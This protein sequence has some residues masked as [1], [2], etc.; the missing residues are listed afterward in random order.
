MA[1]ARPR[2]TTPSTGFPFPGCHGGGPITPPA[3]PNFPPEPPALPVDPPAVPG[4]PSVPPPITE[5]PFG[6]QFD[7]FAEI[8]QLL[9][10][11]L[12]RLGGGPATTTPPPYAMPAGPPG[13]GGPGDA[14]T[15]ENL[16]SLLEQVNA[17]APAHS[18]IGHP[19][20]SNAA[21]GAVAGAATVR[22]G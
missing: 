18:M 10:E 21:T 12:Q 15:L 9:Q 11:L 14:A 5:P 22:K 3:D 2:P 16:Q 6:Q 4:D 20:R 17:G 7:P 19:G 1:V 13:G 8:R